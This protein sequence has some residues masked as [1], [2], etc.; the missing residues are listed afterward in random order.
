MDGTAVVGSIEITVD[1]E[2]YIL[3]DVSVTKSAERVADKDQNGAPSRAAL[4]A[5]EPT[6]SANYQIASSSTTALEIGDEFTVATGEAAGTWIIDNVTVAKGSRAI[7][8]G[9]LAATGKINV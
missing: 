8:K 7:T 4:F 1:T 9:T 3:D 2:D 6:L 5:N